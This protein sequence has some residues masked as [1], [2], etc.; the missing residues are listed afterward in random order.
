MC[1]T[2]DVGQNAMLSAAALGL[3]SCCMAAYDQQVCDNVIGLDGV[4]EYVVY[5]IAVG[6]AEGTTE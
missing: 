6:T 1:Q 3:G 4:D 2:R 5:G